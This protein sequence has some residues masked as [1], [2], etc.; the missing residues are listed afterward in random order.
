M[1]ICL[2]LLNEDIADRFKV[3]G[4]LISQS[5]STWVRATAKVLSSMIKV[6][7][8]DRV[9]RL[10]SKK[11]KPCRTLQKNSMKLASKNPLSSH[12]RNVT[13]LPR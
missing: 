2:G 8:L 13:L 3:S 11:F 1:K 10:K 12:L 7:D 9:H 6:W 5:F 4:T